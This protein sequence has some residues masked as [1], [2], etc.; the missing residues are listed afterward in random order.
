MMYRLNPLRPSHLAMRAALA[1]ALSLAAAHALA[2][3]LSATPTQNPPPVVSARVD[4]LLTHADAVRALPTQ[5]LC[6]NEALQAGGH[7]LVVSRS[8]GGS[9]TLR[10]RQLVAWSPDQPVP[11]GRVD[12]AWRTCGKPT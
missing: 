5:V 12:V 7:W 6:R 10:H 3:P 4:G 2:A 1:G 8:W 11:A 9:P